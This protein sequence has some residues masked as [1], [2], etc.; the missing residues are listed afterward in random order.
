M[1]TYD[2]DGCGLLSL[3]VPVHPFGRR[4]NSRSLCIP[5][6]CLSF[7]SSPLPA[8]RVWSSFNVRHP[9][10]FSISHHH[11]RMQRKIIRL[12]S[13]LQ[14]GNNHQDTYLAKN[15]G[16]RE[17]ERESERDTG[18]HTAECDTKWF[19]GG[20]VIDTCLGLLYILPILGLSY[21]AC[22]DSGID[23]CIGDGLLPH[24]QQVV[25]SGIVVFPLDIFF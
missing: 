12:L 15:C 17:R 11:H 4:S 3:A 9:P 5:L 6:A 18:T 24:L 20:K 13:S 8:S 21:T 23:L 7:P 25:R 10:Q 16:V 14:V 22:I 2:G 19:L 1:R